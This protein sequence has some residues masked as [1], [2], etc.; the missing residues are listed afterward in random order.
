[1]AY[2]DT[3]LYKLT[4]AGTA[5]ADFIAAIHAHFDSAPGA[6]EL[7]PGAT[8]VAGESTAW[9]LKADADHYTALRRSST[10]QFQAVVDHTVSLSNAGDASTP[11]TIPSGASPECSSNTLPTLNADFFLLEHAD[12][13]TILFMDAA[14][15][16]FANGI[17]VGKIATPLRPSWADA[18][19]TGHGALMGVVADAFFSGRNNWFYNSNQS[20]GSRLRGPDTAGAPAWYQPYS[21]LNQFVASTGRPSSTS[22]DGLKKFMVPVTGTLLDVNGSY[23]LNAVIFKYLSILPIGGAFG[24]QYPLTIYSSPV[25]DDEAWISA[26]SSYTQTTMGINWE[27]GQDA[28]H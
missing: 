18:G 23:D 20:D 7:V 26:W 6:W 22:N 9:R 5:A 2:S 25:D 28:V 11:I 17:H 27:Y 24:G 4:A 8:V 12:A 14:K 19:I 15:T 3:V 13:V 16:F 1:M 10:T 21:A